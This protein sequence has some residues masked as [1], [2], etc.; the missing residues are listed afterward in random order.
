[1]YSSCLKWHINYSDRITV[2]IWASRKCE[3]G[4]IKWFLG[5]A[6]GNRFH[7]NIVI[8]ISSSKPFHPRFTVKEKPLNINL[9][10]KL[11]NAFVASL[12]RFGLMHFTPSLET[13]SKVFWFQFSMTWP[14]QRNHLLITSY[15]GRAQQWR[16]IGHFHEQWSRSVWIHRVPNDSWYLHE[17]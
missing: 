17:D 3:N 1:M 2:R 8:I 5:E 4:I 11:I 13:T 12:Y 15:T 7:L 14:L 16:H 10:C 6:C 9:Q